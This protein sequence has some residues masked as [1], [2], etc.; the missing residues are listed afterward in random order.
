[1]VGSVGRV[2]GYK[3]WLENYLGSS[4]PGNYVATFFYM[5]SA[6]CQSRASSNFILLL[7][8]LQGFND[9]PICMAKTHLSLS[10]YPELKGCPKGRFNCHD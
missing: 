2:P 8:S 7:C 5:S 6:S 10:H 9:L 1:M 4:N 3:S